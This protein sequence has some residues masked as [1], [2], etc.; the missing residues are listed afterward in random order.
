MKE[1]FRV[2]PGGPDVQRVGND[3]GVQYV[4]RAENLMEFRIMVSLNHALENVVSLRKPFVVARPWEPT[5][6][7]QSP[8]KGS[9]ISSWKSREHDSGLLQPFSAMLLV[10]DLDGRGY[11]RI[12]T[13]TRIVAQLLKQ[14]RDYHPTLLRLS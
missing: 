14:P 7:E 12:P 6:N 8:N 11:S 13:E 2:T 3:D 10:K 4:V 5:M 1:S 9:I